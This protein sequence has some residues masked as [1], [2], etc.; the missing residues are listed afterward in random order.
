MAGPDGNL[1]FTDQGT[2]PAIGMI[3]P[4]THAISEFSAGLN[5]GSSPGASIV[6]GPDGALW[7]MDGGTTPAIGRIDP[8]THAI[9]EFSS[10]PQPGRALGRLAVGPGRQHLV[11][12]QGH[13]P[14][15]R[16]DQ[17]DHPRDHQFT[18]G[19]NAGQP[20]GRD[21][22]GLGRQRLVHRPGRDDK[23]IG[24]IG[25]GAPAASV[26]RPSVAGQAESD[27]AQQ[28]A[29][30]MSGRRGPDSSP[31]TARSASTATSGCSTAARSP[32]RPRRPYTPT[33]ADAGHQLSCR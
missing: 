30:A 18:V 2:T 5:P 4:T 12:R 28:S 17:P 29:A 25:V 3:N 20:P 10:G 9:T 13:D 27:V 24:R 1:W 14:G 21:G 31:R 16:D 15:D 8:T 22:D 7:F 26:D 23:A 6:V 11:R 33:A 32:V 19:L